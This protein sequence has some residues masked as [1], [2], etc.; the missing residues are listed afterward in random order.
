MKKK[1][2]SLALASAMVLSIN[3]TAFAADTT[4][5]APVASPV[6]ADAPAGLT[7]GSYAASVDVTTKV[8]TPTIKIT[9]PSAIEVGLN[10][11]GLEYEIDS[12]KYTDQIANVEQEIVNESDVPVSIGATVSATVPAGSKAT[13]SSAEVKAAETKNAVFTYLEVAVPSTE[14]VVKF[15]DAY[16]SKA[17]NQVV[18]AAKATTKTGL[19]TLKAGNSTAQTGKFK[20]FG[21]VAQ[22]PTNAWTEDDK[23]DYTVVFAFVPQTAEAAPAT[24]AAP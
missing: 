21:S 10:P 6:A 3:T 23:V 2:L 1:L 22:N 5:E 12:T 4:V 11:Y 13:I 20:L 16:S 14:G 9:V 7:A 15:G 17:T 18:F 19:G 24:T 8:K